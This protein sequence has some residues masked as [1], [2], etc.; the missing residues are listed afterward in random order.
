MSAS[1]NASAA[2]RLVID[3]RIGT[4][5]DGEH[6]G[7]EL[8]PDVPGLTLREQ[9]RQRIAQ[10]IQFGTQFSDRAGRFDTL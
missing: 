3:W 4:D 10:I 8:P 1:V 5:T 2:G 6:Q 9:G 7:L